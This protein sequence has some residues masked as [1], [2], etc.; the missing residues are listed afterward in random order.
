MDKHAED[1]VRGSRAISRRQF[2]Q[3]AAVGLGGLALGGC[4]RGRLVQPGEPQIL[5]APIVTGKSVELCLNSR[6]S[7][8]FVLGGTATTEQMSNILWAAG[9]APVTGSYRT[10]Y[11]KTAAGTSIYQPQDHALEAYST[12]KV[13]NAMRINYDRER[14][15]DAGVSYMLRTA[16]FGVA[17]DG[18]EL[19][20]RGLPPGGRPELRRRR[21]AGADRRACGDVLRRVAARPF[22]RRRRQAGGCARRAASGRGTPPGPR[23]HAATALAAPLGSLRLHAARHDHRSGGPDRAVLGGP[24]LPHESPLCRGRT[25]RAVLQSPGLRHG[26]LAITGWSWCR[27]R[28]CGPPSARRCPTCPRR[29]VMCSCA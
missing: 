1:I 16:C 17:L 22:H 12:E 29:R 6:V 26:Q 11:L 25:R 8:H 28:T 14:D 21:R 24:V 7:K 27:M 15:F 18:H 2:C 9:R 19:P 20:A 4:L 3:T 13:V 23:P 5:P 10:I